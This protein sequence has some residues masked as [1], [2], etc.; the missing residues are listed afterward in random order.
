MK[1]NIKSWTMA[2]YWKWDVK[3]EDICGIC[4]SDLDGCCQ[5]CLMPGDDC[6]VVWGEC[7][8][9][10][11]LHCIERWGS[12]HAPHHTCPLDRKPWQTVSAP[13]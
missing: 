12:E 10:F 11:H 1:M 9:V 13:T 8:H 4:Q 5:Q 6:P 2:A 3:D 7:G